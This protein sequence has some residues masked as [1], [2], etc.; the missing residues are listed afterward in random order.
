[1]KRSI[2]TLS[3]GILLACSA[4]AA[5]PES[6]D[7]TPRKF[8]ARD[9]Y[10]RARTLNMA[11]YEEHF[12]PPGPET[13]W[14]LAGPDHG[15]FTFF[16]N[17]DNVEACKNNSLAFKLTDNEAVLG[18]GNIDN[19]QAR[20]KRVG[21][22]DSAIIRMDIRQSKPAE[23]T[24]HLFPWKDGDRLPGDEPNHYFKLKAATAGTEWTNVVFK[25][26]DRSRGAD[27]FDLVM[28][29]RKDNQ[30][31][32]RN[33]EIVRETRK[34]YFRKVIEIPEGTVWR[35]A[36]N[37][38]DH[39]VLFINGR[40][41]PD[42]SP[43]H[44]RPKH[45]YTSVPVDLKPHLRP[46]SNCIGLLATGPT[47]FKYT[48]AYLQG[49]VVMA[50]GETV[51]VNTDASWQWSREPCD[52]WSSADSP[53]QAWPRMREPGRNGE[54]AAKPGDIPW[55]YM[56]NVGRPAYD[57]MVVLENP[58]QERLYYTDSSPVLI[59]VRVPAGLAERGPGI[60]W[61]IRQYDEKGSRRVASG[62]RDAYRFSN[63]SLVFEIEPGNLAR[64]V[65][66]LRT[67][68]KDP[69]GVIEE[70]LPEPLIVV[71]RIP[72]KEI[73]GDAFEQG[74]DRTLETTVDFTDRDDPHPTLETDGSG[75]RLS[76]AFR[77]PQEYVRE[78][79]RPD[80]EK[81]EAERQRQAAKPDLDPII[82]ERNGLTYRETRPVYGALFS[83]Q[84]EFEH[85]GDFY[86]MVL[87]YPNDRSR[88]ISVECTEEGY[89]SRCNP[90]VWTGDRF[91]LTD[92]LQ[93]L[94]WIYRPGPGKHAVHIGSQRKESSAAAA[95]L[96]IYH[97]GP[98][99]PALKQSQ[100][101]QRQFGILTETS[102]ARG[103]SFEKTFG[104]KNMDIKREQRWKWYKAPSQEEWKASGN[105]L[106]EKGYDRLVY[107]LD[108]CE[109]FA[110]YL[111]FVG[112][113]SHFMGCWQYGDGQAITPRTDIPGSSR[114]EM[115]FRDMA[116]QVFN[117]NDISFYGSIQFVYSTSFNNLHTGTDGLA[118]LP[119][120]LWN[121]PYLIDKHG[122]E[123]DWSAGP[124]FQTGWNFNHPV[125][126]ERML[127][128]AEA[129]ARRYRD[130][131]SFRGINWSCYLGGDYMPIWN[132]RALSMVSPDPLG[133]G[134]G[135]VTIRAFEEDTGI[136]LNADPDDPNR[137]QERYDKLN[138][139]GMRHRWI[140]WRSEQIAEVFVDIGR[141][142][143]R[144]RADLEVLATPMVYG[145]HAKRW[146][147]SG[148]TAREFLALS[149]WDAWHFRHRDAVS[150]THYTHASPHNGVVRW[151]LDYLHDLY[152][153]FDDEWHDALEAPRH[154]VAMVK[155]SWNE[156]D[157]MATPLPYRENWPVTEDGALA[158]AQPCADNVREMFTSNLIRSDTRVFMYDLLHV[159]FFVGQEQE[160][161]EFARV[162]RALPE[163]RFSTVLD[164][165]MA[166]DLAIRERREPGRYLFYVANP[167]PWRVRGTV[168]VEGATAVVNAVSGEPVAGKGMFRS[169]LAVPVELDGFG[170]AAFTANSGDARVTA[171]DTE[172]LPAED[173]SHVRKA[174]AQFKTLKADP[175]ARYALDPREMAHL[176]K[177]AT[178]IEQALEQNRYAAAW[179]VVSRPQWIGAVRQMEK[180]AVF[181]TESKAP[182]SVTTEKQ[183]LPVARV[184]QAPSLDGRLDE[185]VW[186]HAEVDRGFITETMRPSLALTT[187]RAV[188]HGN[189]LY[190]AFECKD[191][192]PADIKIDA[193]RE[194]ESTV[195]RDDCIAMFIQPDRERSTYYQMAFNAAGTLFDQRVVGSAR[196]YDFAP[197]WNVAARVTD[198]GWVA[199]VRLPAE[200]LDGAI[201]PDRP[202]GF[203]CHR[204][205]RYNRIMTSSWSF[206]PPDV[207]T[208]GSWHNPNGFG[209]LRFQ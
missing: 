130:L 131:P 119:G 204:A 91:P 85:P 17:I 70:R 172:A 3:V 74:M 20:D 33:V 15:S 25:L 45:G 19:K 88:W 158:Q 37:I 186:E 155:F 47:H 9:L 166:T 83:V 102:D 168:T 134:Y 136:R 171:W 142:V 40:Q 138:A 163:G 14:N 190:L 46:G 48:S 97:V 147:G 205:F 5:A 133:A 34:G 191:R 195:F 10:G 64:G 44:R 57:G 105:D 167:C 161:R 152:L 71:G 120:V 145:T 198:D 27:G 206:T 65:Y 193:V 72:M 129:V 110:Q 39:T 121:S 79:A 1:M 6:Q 11:L 24:W 127:S 116:A 80:P 100:V 29:G 135:D 30:L 151:W 26:A 93:E 103:Q 66:Q 154:R 180:G 203:N 56:A 173:L 28:Q 175:R 54:P 179:Q 87:E 178:G 200:A 140:S 75:E 144:E 76:P 156:H 164:T 176:E 202:W 192:D 55:Y 181:G 113:N 118:D 157:G 22:W 95:R 137:F 99:L 32:I 41:I 177:V 199:E 8:L 38:G 208:A 148:R 35:A 23:T 42:K 124:W 104:F 197:D 189:T 2:A 162:L 123:L 58:E 150:L 98:T 170:V 207:G 52:G 143:R 187:V 51:S 117:A 109:H 94:K 59:R 86:Q 84:L 96:R 60:V 153:N 115:A 68:L 81:L 139:E 183:T 43:V 82:V 185:K 106:A 92:T 184:E 209:L 196:D 67:T 50:S 107:W 61:S 53:A 174:L 182:V 16:E 128:V 194:K 126:R 69:D 122:R 77:S 160:Y 18:W 4:F 132:A 165:G 188:H 36:A 31:Q 114:V 111:R 89:G 159:L 112:Q 49:T 62:R 21:L 7:P 78:Q 108:T 13:Q 201:E 101:N 149:G 125:I 146:K 63:D 169:N 12:T 73:P 90:M 141:R